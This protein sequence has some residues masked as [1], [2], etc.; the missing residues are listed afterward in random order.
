MTDLFTRRRDISSCPWA[1][2]SHLGK[3]SNEK[4]HTWTLVNDGTLWSTAHFASALSNVNNLKISD[5]LLLMLWFLVML[6]FFPLILTQKSFAESCKIMK[7]PW[8]RFFFDNLKI[9]LVEVPFRFYLQLCK[10]ILEW[11]LSYEVTSC[12][13]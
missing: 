9:S 2:Q 8:G 5:L 3:F 10:S 13:L 6:L 4:L 1:S 12:N 7:R 11:L